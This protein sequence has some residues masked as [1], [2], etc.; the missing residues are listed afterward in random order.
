M[1]CELLKLSHP[2][3]SKIPAS[4]YDAKKKLRSL[5][6]GYEM[7]HVCK[8]DCA[9]FWKENANLHECPVCGHT[10]WSKKTA[11]GRNISHKVLC[12]FPLKGRQRRLFS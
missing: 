5:G 1:L 7:I 12:Y 6:L 3:D 10:R 2:K 8:Y 4:Y 11:K 9:L